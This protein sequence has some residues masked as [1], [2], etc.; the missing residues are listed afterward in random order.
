[1]ICSYCKRCKTESPGDVCRI[2]GKHA[3]A[4]SQRDVWSTASV[5][6]ADSRI[7]KSIVITLIAVALLLTVVVFGL[8]ALVSDAGKVRLLWSSPLPRLIFL[9]VPL[10]LAVSF[11]FLTIQGRETIVY[12]LDPQG[13]HLQTWHQPSRLKSWSRLQS[14][15]P[16]CDVPQQDGTVMHLSQE[17]HLI[18]ADVQSVRYRPRIAAIYL[19]HT[20]R[21]APMVLKL[22]PEEYETAAAYVGKYCKVKS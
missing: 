21:L 5:P 19:Y 18:W 16:A 11:L 20:P 9:I 22:P 8:E 13:A 10:G 4:G 15:D 17:R 12:V 1:M 3:A 7:W 14:A 2:C 6:L